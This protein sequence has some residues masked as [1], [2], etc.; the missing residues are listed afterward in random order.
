MQ[1]IIEK[2]RNFMLE[3]LQIIKK[4]CSHSF[5]SFGFG[6]TLASISQNTELNDKFEVVSWTSR[7]QAT[8]SSLFCWHE[9]VRIRLSRSSLR[10]KRYIRYN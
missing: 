4:G 2:K 3:M 8:K 10:P 1:E 9:R 6:L 7:W 5:G